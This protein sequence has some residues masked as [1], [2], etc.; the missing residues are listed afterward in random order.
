MVEIFAL[1]KGYSSG[2]FS[3]GRDGDVGRDFSRDL[4]EKL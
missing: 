4:S 3:H 2:V 1:S